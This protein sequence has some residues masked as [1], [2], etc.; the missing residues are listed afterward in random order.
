MTARLLKP[1]EVATESIYSFCVREFEKA[2]I[3]EAGKRAAK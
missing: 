1:F 2:V 3:F